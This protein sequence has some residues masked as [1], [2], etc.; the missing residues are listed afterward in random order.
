VVFDE[1]VLRFEASSRS[2]LALVGGIV[3]PDKYGIAVG[4][5]SPLRESI[6]GVLLAMNTDGTLAS[7]KNRWFGN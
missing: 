7:L 5:G 6:N 4:T 3:D 2:K 1:P